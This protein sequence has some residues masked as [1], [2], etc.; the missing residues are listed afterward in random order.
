MPHF[1]NG[2][3][4]IFNGWDRFFDGREEFL[5]LTAWIVFMM[6][7]IAFLMLAMVLLSLIVMDS[8]QALAHNR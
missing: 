5:I 4:G 8:V 7:G 6:D 3:G 2:S 1:V